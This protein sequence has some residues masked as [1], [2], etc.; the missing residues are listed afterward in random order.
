[1]DDEAGRFVAEPQLTF[2]HPYPPTKIMFVPDKDCNR[3][4]LLAT[5][6]DFLRIWQ[7]QEDGVQLVKVLNNVRLVVPCFTGCDC[8]HNHNV[9]VSAAR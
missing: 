2:Q 3:P 4:D 6:G 5:T 7:L 8:L 9:H 1:M